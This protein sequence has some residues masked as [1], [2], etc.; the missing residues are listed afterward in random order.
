VSPLAFRIL[1]WFV[2]TKVASAF[3]DSHIAQVIGYLA[4]TDLQVGLLLNFR[5]SEL[6][7]QRL[8]R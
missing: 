5:Y 4:I 2:D 8:V 6:G 7:W 3:S 1:L